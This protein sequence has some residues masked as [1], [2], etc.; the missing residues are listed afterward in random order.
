MRELLV[1]CPEAR[2]LVHSDLLHWNVLVANDRVT[3]LLDWGSSIYG[4]FVYDIAW[5]TFWWPWYPGWSGIEIAREAREH[6]ERIGL[7]VPRFEERLRCYELRIGLDSL[8]WYSSRRDLVNLE[9]AA[10]RIE[11]LI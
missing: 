2:H 11:A 5:L 1:H 9:L 8:V 6:Y 3:A 4:D 7:S 10:Q